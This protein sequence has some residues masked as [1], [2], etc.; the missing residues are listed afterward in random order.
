MVTVRQAKPFNDPVWGEI[1]DEAAKHYADVLTLPIA[2]SFI[3]A[4]Q[5]R[6]RTATLGMK[7]G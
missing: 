4:E 3:E 2:F 1:W 5:S 6:G 7:F